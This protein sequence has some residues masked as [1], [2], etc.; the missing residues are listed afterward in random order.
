[1][2]ELRALVDDFASVTGRNVLILDIPDFVQALAKCEN[3]FAPRF[4]RNA[5]EEPDH[6]HCRLLRACPKRP[7]SRR[8][9]E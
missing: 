1:L 5:I 2:I 7:G 6:R 4:E 9:A 3:G 8:A